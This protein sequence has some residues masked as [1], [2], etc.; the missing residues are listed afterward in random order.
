[1]KR[2]LEYRY[3]HKYD[4]KAFTERNKNVT[5]ESIILYDFVCCSLI[6]IVY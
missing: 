3:G 2:G 1:M 4:P 5:V 6:K